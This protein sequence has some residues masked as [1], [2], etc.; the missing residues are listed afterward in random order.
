MGSADNGFGSITTT[1]RPWVTI[2]GTT[3]QNQYRK[4]NIPY[5][6]GHN[7]GLWQTLGFNYRTSPFN[8]YAELMQS[9]SDNTVSAPLMVDEAKRTLDIVDYRE[10]LDKVNSLSASAQKTSLLAELA[11]LKTTL[12][13]GGKRYLV[14]FGTSG[15]TTSGNWNNFTNCANGQSLL[16]MTAD[17]GTTG[18]VDLNITNAFS[19]DTL[20]KDLTTAYAAGNFSGLPISSN[21]DGMTISE[22]GNFTITGVTQ[23]D[24]VEVRFFYTEVSP[25]Y[26]FRAGAQASVEGS[27]LNFYDCQFNTGLIRP[28]TFDVVVQS[29]N[30]CDISIQPRSTS[31]RIYLVAA[32]IFVH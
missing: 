17:D 29:D 23:G 1:N 2:G 20:Q 8:W 12:D 22:A 6:V 16:N 11:S 5:G 14:D 28:Q 10:A 9:S 32:E 31:R 3:A 15:N 25:N 19:A 30:D 4:L 24:Q 27:A 18:T 13:G 26:L 21:R 7:S